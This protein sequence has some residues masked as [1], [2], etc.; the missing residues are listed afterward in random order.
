MLARVEFMDACIYARKSTNKIGQKETIENQFEICNYEAPRYRLR[1]VEQRA[2]SATGRDD[3]HRP[4]IQEMI[5]AAIAGKYKCV[6]MKG[7]SRFFRDVENGLGL[8]KLLDR[9][10]IRVITIEESFDSQKDRT[11][12][13][14]LDTSKITMYLM[15][16]EMESK[17]HGDRI[18]LQQLA[19]ARRGEWINAANPP[20]GYY[21][22]KETLKIHRDYLTNETAQLI[23]DLYDYHDMG[24][25]TIMA[26]LEGDNPAGDVY[27]GPTGQGWNDY[28]IRYI[29]RNPVYAGDYYFNVRTR[30]EMIYSNPEMKGKTK[31][32]FWIGVEINDESEWVVILDCF[33]AT[34]TREQFDRVQEKMDTKAKRKGIRN[35]VSLLATIGKCK[36]CGSSLTFKRGNLDANGNIK[37][38]NNYY[39]MNYIKYGKR[40]CTSHHIFAEKLENMIMDDIHSMVTDE[41][42]VSKL[43]SDL[44]NHVPA[45]A[46]KDRS[47]KDRIEKE[48]SNISRKMDLLLN[49]NLEGDITDQQYKTMNESYSKE[50]DVAVGKLKTISDKSAEKKTQLTKEKKLKL[51]FE[52][53]VNIKELSIDKQRMLLLQLVDKV[54]LDINLQVDI[55]YRFSDP[56]L[57]L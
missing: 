23:Y 4:E 49:K 55:T 17:K 43:F 30:K 37:T 40:R 36:E 44:K 39:C 3:I 42:F 16:A 33:E 13:G 53:A 54:E 27:P 34:V 52:S 41:A 18:K 2:D 20:F 15:F 25:R 5:E 11:S 14:K 46:V 12:N 48:I 19:K 56:K 21:Y 50:L 28:I 57:L 1:I 32:D 7:V 51:A 47:D 22:N 31:E 26:Y 38:R 10:G 29:L 8:I 35:N 24:V 45:S 6:I 9:H